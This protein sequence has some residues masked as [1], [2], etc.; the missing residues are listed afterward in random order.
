MQS[1]HKDYLSIKFPAIIV[2]DKANEYK[3][4]DVI[5]QWSDFVTLGRAPA[6]GT[7]IA[8]FMFDAN[9]YIYRYDSELG[10]PRLT[11]RLCSFLDNLVVPGLLFKIISSFLYFGPD[12]GTGKREELIVFRRKLLECLLVHEKGEDAKQVA[13]LLEEAHSPLEV[14]K[15]V[16]WYRFYGGRRDKDGHLLG[17]GSRR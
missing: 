9:G 7:Y 8:G 2:E 15:S 16:D 4:Y 3:I 14:I 11:K 13:V 12:V 6:K 10:W 5:Y 17:Q 1:L